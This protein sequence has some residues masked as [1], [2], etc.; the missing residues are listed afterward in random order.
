MKGLLEQDK[1]L[2]LESLKGLIEASTILGLDPT[3]YKNAL[4]TLRPER[5]AKKPNQRAV[6]KKRAASH[7]GPR[8]KYRLT[9]SKVSENR[10][11]LH[12]SGPIDSKN[13]SHF[14]LKRKKSRLN[15]FDVTPAYLPYSIK[16][17]RGKGF[18][19]IRIAQFD[20]KKIRIV[21]ETEK[22]YRPT[23][24]IDG[25]MLKISLPSLKKVRQKS[26]QKRSSHKTAAGV[27]SGSSASHVR[28]QQGRNGQSADAGKYR[29]RRYTVVVDPG[30]GG[31]DGG[32]VGYQRRKEKDAVLAV[33]KQLKKVLRKRGFN[34]Y[35]TRESDI[36]IP[37]KK[38]TRYANKKQADFFISIHANAAPTK[39]KYMKNKGIETYFLSPARTG[40]AKRVAAIENRADIKNIDYYTKDAYLTMLNRE[41]II[42]SNKLAIDLQKQLLASVR[43]KYK[44]VVDHGVR[45]GPFWVLVG[46]QM[47]AVLIEIGYITHPTEARRL[48]NPYYQKLLAEGVANGIESYIYHKNRSP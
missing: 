19:E 32:A 34:V 20:P 46:A 23:F 45:K 35:L 33:A 39:R 6:K 28:T 3:R 36:F 44:D 2:Q 40:R 41:K 22:Y 26:E 8:K 16:R 48:F 43:R 5:S 47:P 29:F 42:E 10:L 31:K 21:I 1:R 14:V 27:S 7:E 9:G 24:S 30:H 38:R 12:F 25:N 15:V 18:K 4:K 13:V 17:I 11:I 37:L